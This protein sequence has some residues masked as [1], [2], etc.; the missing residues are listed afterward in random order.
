VT[1]PERC[2]QPTTNPDGRCGECVPCLRY[3]IARLRSDLAAWKKLA[4]ELVKDEWMHDH[5][6]TTSGSDNYKMHEK[7]L[8]QARRGVL[9]RPAKEKGP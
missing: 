2:E 4:R 6:W 1:D 7:R 3:T 8:S 5:S 9:A